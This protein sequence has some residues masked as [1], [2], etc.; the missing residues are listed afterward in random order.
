MWVLCW[1]HLFFLMSLM[2]RSLTSWSTAWSHCWQM[3]ETPSLQRTVCLT[4]TLPAGNWLFHTP[5]FY[6]GK[7]FMSFLLPRV[8]DHLIQRNFLSLSTPPP[9]IPRHL[10]M[11]AGL[12]H[13]RVHLNV[14]EFRQQNHMTFFCNVLDILKLLQPLVFHSDHQRALQDCL[15]SFMR[16]LQVSSSTF[17]KLS[18]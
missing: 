8:K 18:C 9:S 13:G 10:P 12:L 7:D 15:L 11:I 14:H 1:V 6:S 5:F 16:V 4:L 2:F 3:W 17:L